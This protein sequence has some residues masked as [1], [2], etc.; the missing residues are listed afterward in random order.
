MMLTI[1][2]PYVHA[3]SLFVARNRLYLP[4][5]LRYFMLMYE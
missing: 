4:E 5:A 1:Y 2:D 3:D